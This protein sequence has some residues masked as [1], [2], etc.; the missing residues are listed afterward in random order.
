MTA[1]KKTEGSELAS[2]ERADLQ[3]SRDGV[4]LRTLTQARNA[5]TTVRTCLSVFFQVRAEVPDRD[6]TSERGLLQEARL[7]GSTHAR[8]QLT[9]ENTRA[10]VRAP[11]KMFRRKQI[12]EIDMR[13]TF[14]MLRSRESGGVHN[15]VG[16]FRAQ[17]GQ[18]WRAHTGLATA[19]QRLRTSTPP[20]LRPVP[21]SR[22]AR[23]ASCH[24]C[25]TRDSAETAARE[26]PPSA[27]AG[28]HHRARE[29]LR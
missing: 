14:F 24:A 21:Q 12:C 4:R 18:P 19:P 9:C 11:L 27:G 6:I 17:I 20:S 23:V 28:A 15:E 5:P 26:E 22:D 10:R 2:L 7:C 16:A 8:A 13:S 1:G 29:L 25:S 3:P